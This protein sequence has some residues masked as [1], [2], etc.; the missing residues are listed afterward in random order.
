VWARIRSYW[1][2]IFRRST[3]EDDLA[4]ELR[5]HL[6][7]RAPLRSRLGMSALPSRDREGVGA[8]GRQSRT[9]FNGVT[10]GLRPTN[11][12]EDAL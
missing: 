11:V 6:A 5:A 4:E 1:Q 2:G 12:D 7:E 8:V 10:M 3:V 9:V